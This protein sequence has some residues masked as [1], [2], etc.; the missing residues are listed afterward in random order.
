MRMKMHAQ[1]ANML[2]EIIKMIKLTLI[3][4][5]CISNIQL[6][7][8]GLKLGKAALTDVAQKDG[9]DI[10]KKMLCPECKKQ[11]PSTQG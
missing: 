3:C 8:T 9:W 11:Q 2:K 4:D 7:V 5:K 1:H 6:D 10:G